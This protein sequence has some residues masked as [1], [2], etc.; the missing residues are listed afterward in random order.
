MLQD[1]PLMVDAPTFDTTL[2]AF[3]EAHNTSK[4]Q[5]SFQEAPCRVNNSNQEKSLGESLW[6]GNLSNES[7]LLDPAL[8]GLQVNNKSSETQ[9]VRPAAKHTEQSIKPRGKGVDA[10]AKKLQ[11]VQ[12]RRKVNTDT[13]S[14]ANVGITKKKAAVHNGGRRRKAPRRTII[15]LDFPNYDHLKIIPRKPE[16]VIHSFHEASNLSEIAKPRQ[17]FKRSPIPEEYKKNRANETSMLIMTGS[18]VKRPGVV[19]KRR[20]SVNV[21]A[22]ESIILPQAQ[23]SK[24]D[25]Q[26]NNWNCEEEELGE[27]ATLTHQSASRS[28]SSGSRKVDVGTMTD[29][30]VVTMTVEEINQVLNLVASGIQLAKVNTQGAAVQEEKADLLRILGERISSVSM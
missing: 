3:E 9:R 12:P 20:S 10:A 6:E 28:K 29:Q 8:P 15:H 24:H 18:F 22:I 16:D 1:S 11:D 7:T 4:Q 30:S 23:R 17:F 2:P 5:K 19:S 21:S 26:P 13:V 14:Q 25:Q 27:K